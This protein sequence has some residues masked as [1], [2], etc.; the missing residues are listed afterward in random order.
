M[1]IAQR[2]YEGIDIGGETTGLITYM[3]TDGMQIDNSAITQ[4]PKDLRQAYGNPYVPETPRQHQSKPKNA[5][6]AHGAIQPT[7]LSPPPAGNRRRV[8]P[9]LRWSS[10]WRNSASAVRQP[11]PRSCRC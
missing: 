10:G 5:P 7:D 11:T 3:R 8:F 2:L 1:R 4:A 6:E 9:R